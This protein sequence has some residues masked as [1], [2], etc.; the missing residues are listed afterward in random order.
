MSTTTLSRDLVSTNLDLWSDEVLA[1]PYPHYK[2]LRDL[3]PA[4]YLSRY[5]MWITT[6]YDVVKNALMDWESFSSAHL[7][8]VALSKEGQ[9]AWRGSVLES[10]PPVH[11]E[12]RKVFND[13][14]RPK[15]ILK[16]TGDIDAR[17]E[18]VIDDLLER[19]TFDGVADFGR[20]LPMN[21][22]MDLVGW[23]DE[24][25]D[26]M[27]EWADGAFNALGPEG[28][29]RMLSA[30]PKLQAGL[31]YVS[32][33][34]SKD[35][36][37][38]GSFGR[39]MFEAAESGTVPAEVVPI[40]LNGFMHA[41]LDTT[42]HSMGNLLML[43]TQHPEQWE[44]VRADP[45]LVS[46]AYQEGLRLESPIQVF[47][48]ATTRDVDLGDGVVIPKDSRVVHSY[49]AANR[50]ERHYDNPEQ[51]NIHRNVQDHLAFDF[52]T[53]ACPGRRLATMEANALFTA[54]ARRVKTIEL[55]GEPKRELNNTTRGWSSLPMRF[56]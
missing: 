29:E 28:N 32:E 26:K 35:R 16:A 30:F 3:G 12:R 25:R 24:G 55:V 52:G 22:V 44:M 41:S 39:M 23:P 51:F 47:S 43:F 7:G 56:S 49:A 20:D 8:G 36:M 48:R 6:R 50:D 27:L 17:A 45:S 15:S 11:G 9:E 53:H 33:N 2:M 34:A 14:L 5:D 1:D 46:Q 54:M 19:G 10:D 38:P 21:I 42:I 13:V 4:A 31:D 18:K 37:A 40:A